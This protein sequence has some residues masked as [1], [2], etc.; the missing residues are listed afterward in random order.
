M[1]ADFITVTITDNDEFKVCMDGEV[2]CVLK[3]INV[4]YNCLYKSITRSN[5]VVV[6]LRNDKQLEI[7]RSG[8]YYNFKFLDEDNRL[9]KISE[10]EFMEFCQGIIDASRFLGKECVAIPYELTDAVDTVLS[11]YRKEGR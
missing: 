4:L 1:K 6:P 9:V 2:F 10:Y 5:R 8:C 7:Q 3:Y 11:R